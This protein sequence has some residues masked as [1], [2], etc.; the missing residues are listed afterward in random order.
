[1]NKFIKKSK[2]ES[3][4]QDS[5]REQRDSIVYCDEIN[6]GNSLMN[7]TTVT[8]FNELSSMNNDI[9]LIPNYYYQGI[10]SNKQINSSQSKKI[11]NTWADYKI[12]ISIIDYYRNKIWGPESLF[13]TVKMVHDPKK[14]LFEDCQNLLNH[15]GDTKEYRNILFKS[16]AK[17]VIVDDNYQKEVF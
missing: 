17:L 14:P 1:M 15:Y 4:L 16:I 10:Y 5:K 8:E 9:N 7:K 2:D 3:D 12:Y 11:E 6:D 13:K